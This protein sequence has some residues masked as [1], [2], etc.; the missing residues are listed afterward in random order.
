MQEW[1]AKKNGKCLASSYE[2]VKKKVEWE[3]EKGHR[4]K[5]DF[6]HVIHGKSWCPACVNRVP[7]TIEE[8]RKIAN[9]RGGECLSD[10]IVN[11]DTHLKWKCGKG[12]M[13]NA[14]PSSIIGGTWCPNC[15][16][17]HKTIEDMHAAAAKHGGK[18]LSSKYIKW[19]YHL[20]WKCL[21]GHTWKATPNNV[22]RGYWC[23]KCGHKR[24]GI[25]RRFAL[26]DCQRVA[27]EKGGKCLS[28]KY[29]GVQEHMIW[30]CKKGHT[31]KATFDNVKRE[32]WCPKCCESRNEKRCR[33]IFE[34]IYQKPFVKTRSTL[35]DRLELDGY[36]KK[37]NIAFEYNGEQHYKRHYHWH[38]T[39]DAFKKQ[40]A[41]DVKKVR[42]CKEKG[43]ALI[44]IP[45]TEQDR[46][47]E[48]IKE[49]LH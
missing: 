16:G 4:W 14:T 35:Q 18:C 45:Y 27:E 48:F 15:I 1:A 44:T 30:E 36:C 10:N 39:A 12:H 19:N 7:R 24:R 26:E 43:I 47:E 13:W 31:W 2:G 33:E 6:D 11:V 41:R 20:E 21:E 38:K 40:Q 28:L 29:K 42:L 34:Q 25:K 9:S 23:K 3:C 22:L 46:L 32:T 8:M 17:R 37:L 49:Q 5:I